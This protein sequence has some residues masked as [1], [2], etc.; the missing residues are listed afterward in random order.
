[1]D[2]SKMIADIG[3]MLKKISDKSLIIKIYNIVLH[4]YNK[5]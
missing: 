1:M 2:K 4:I 5:Q 3:N